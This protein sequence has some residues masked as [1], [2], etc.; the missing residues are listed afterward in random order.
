MQSLLKQ[1]EKFNG[2]QIK[3][4]IKFSIPCVDCEARRTLHSEWST[5][6]SRADESKR[7]SKQVPA[8]AGAG[9][10]Q[11]RAA[12]SHKSGKILT[13]CTFFYRSA[14]GTTAYYRKRYCSSFNNLRK[15][16]CAHKDFPTVSCLCLR[17]NCTT[18]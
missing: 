1:C 16:C 12:N 6:H 8:H 2:I 10:D 9:S 7:S 13:G 14:I 15:K 18:K 17:Q 5:V 4:G 11:T 3:A